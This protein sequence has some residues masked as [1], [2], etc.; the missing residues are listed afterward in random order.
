[1]APLK[2]VKR[3]LTRENIEQIRLLFG[4]KSFLPELEDFL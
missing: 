3:K 4:K 2:N 1:M